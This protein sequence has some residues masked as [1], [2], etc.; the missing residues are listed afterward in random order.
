MSVLDQI[1]KKQILSA[2]ETVN[3]DW[4][5]PS[6]SLDDRT[7]PFT[8]AVK[9]ENG[10]SVN[11]KM[12]IQISDDDINFGNVPDTDVVITDDSGVTIYDINGSGASFARVFIEVTAGSIDVIEIK[13]VGSQFH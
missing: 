11:M 13:Y 4:N 6:F 12:W 3:S 9:Y 5:G 2:P 10:T 1:R 7:G 8:I